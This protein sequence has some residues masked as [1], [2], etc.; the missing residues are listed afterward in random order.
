MQAVY[1]ERLSSNNTRLSRIGMNRI[2]RII[3]LLALLPQTLIVKGQEDT[4]YFT[5]PEVTLIGHRNLSA[6]SGTMASGLRIDAKLMET[7]PKMFGYTDPMLYLQSLPGVSTNSEQSSGLHVQGGESSHNIITVSGIPVYG[8]MN[9]TGLFS[10]FNQDHLPKVEFST[11]DRMPHIGACLALDHADTIPAR[12]SG[13]ATLGLISGQGTLHAPLSAGTYLTLSARR[14]FINAIY[15]PMLEFDGSPF[16]YGFTD[17]NFTLFHRI[18]S[19]NTIDLNALWSHDVGSTTYGIAKIDMN[20]HWGNTLASLRWRHQDKTVRSKTSLFISRYNFQGDI[21]NELINGNINAHIT[22]AGVST[23][24]N[25]PHNLNLDADLSLF[26]ILPQDPHITD[27]KVIMSSQVA[28]KSFLG[29]LALNRQFKAGRNWN[30]IPHLLLSAYNVNEGYECVNLDP[31]LTIGLNLYR[32]GS[33]TAESGIKHQYLSQTGMTSAGL[34]N[35]FWL[36]AGRYFKPQQSVFGTLTY[37]LDFKQSMYSLSVQLYG[38][39]LANQLEY[40]GFLFDLLTRPYR[41][42]DNLL[43]CSGYNYGI[44]LMIA[45]QAGKVTGWISYSYGQSIRRGDGELFP[46]CFHSSHE[47]AHELNAVLSYKIG[48]FD[49]GGNLTMASGNPYTPAKNLYLL[50]NSLFI[51]YDDYNSARLPMYMR[52]DLSA[53]YNLPRR[54]NLDQSINLSVYNATAHNNYNMGYIRADEDE[55]TIRYKLAKLVIPVIPSISYSCRF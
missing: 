23:A 14:S 24:I 29:N 52:L 51:Y 4:I 53:T 31:A 27:N 49:L 16:R 41:L 30:F 20:V 21:R 36:S 37:D 32:Y 55:M 34:P 46:T 45:K 10:L 25:L 6:I 47:R 18:D 13:T 33:F 54:R 17:A 1:K 15:G 26:Q 2:I 42:E 48:K 38:K 50:S 22:N 19:R 9:F 35:E 28:Q 39:L 11:S 12:L 3:I 44:N 43:I 5:I 8:N 40:T 7:Y